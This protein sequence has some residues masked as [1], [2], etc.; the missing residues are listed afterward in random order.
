MA[1]QTS[2]TSTESDP[3]ALD[4]HAA[5][6][7]LDAPALPPLIAKRRNTGTWIGTAVAVLVIA[8]GGYGYWRYAQ[9]HKPPDVTYK[10]TP[11]ET[12]KI[13]GR[14]TASGTLQALVTVQVGSQ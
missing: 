14:I 6:P 8:G 11:I 5:P 4:E 3:R 10:T 7:A 12:R 1:T 9:A 13:V 2:P